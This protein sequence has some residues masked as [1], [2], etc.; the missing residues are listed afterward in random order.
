MEKSSS[1]MKIAVAGAAF[2]GIIAFVYTLQRRQ[3]LKGQLPNPVSKADPKDCKVQKRSRFRTGQDKA[4]V[5]C[6]R[7]VSEYTAC[8]SQV[9]QSCDSVLVV[10]STEKAGDISETITSRACKVVRF[11]GKD[12]WDV[13]FLQS[14]GSISVVCINYTDAFGNFLL[15]DSVA[16]IR[17]L[18]SVFDP[19]LRY[20]IVKDKG[21]SRHA[22]S[23]MAYDLFV[24]A[25]ER[26][27]SIELNKF[28]EPIVIC[29][30]GV[31]EYRM[32]IPLIVEKGDKILEI[33]C[34]RGTTVAM[35]SEYIGSKDEGGLCVGV[36]MGV[37]CIENS[38]KDHLELMSER[39]HLFFEVCNGWDIPGLKQIS[40]DFNIIFVDVG[41][42]SGSDG[43]FEGI[44]FIRQLTCA[45][46]NK[47]PKQRLRYIVVKSRCLRDHALSFCSAGMF[48]KNE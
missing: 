22:D 9:V 19:H 35:A 12:V 2:A 27:K 5:L 39:P 7:S 43:E 15:C 37:V 38:R 11:K 44:S 40:E 8:I 48:L 14:V 4:R 41:G 16:M 46:S 6:C 24:Q 30:V 23:Y 34:A 18:R 10:D 17:L 29:A 25:H 28:W 26:R 31:A 13:K 42:I 33:G 20:I 21:L 3:I 1:G 36:D 45:F 32:P 47:N